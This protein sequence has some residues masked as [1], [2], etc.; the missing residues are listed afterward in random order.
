MEEADQLLK[1]LSS[2]V[3][4]Q[5]DDFEPW[6]PRMTSQVIDQ[7]EMASLAHACLQY[8]DDFRYITFITRFNT[9]YIII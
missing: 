3:P 6:S 5:V 7:E 8:G 1:A 9:K 2:P 4:Q